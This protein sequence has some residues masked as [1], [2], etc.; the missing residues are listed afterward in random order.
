LNTSPTGTALPDGAPVCGLS[1]YPPAVLIT[2]HSHFN[3]SPTSSTVLVVPLEGTERHRMSIIRF[4]GCLLFV[5]VAAASATAMAQPAATT[6]KAS[7]LPKHDVVGSAYPEPFRVTNYGAKCDGKVIYG[8]VTV[9]QGNPTIST[10]SYMF[11][12]GDIGATI[13]LSI[14]SFNGHTAAALTSFSSS[15]VSVSKGNATMAD[16]ASFSGGAAARWYHTVDTSAIQAA[17]DAVS[18]SGVPGGGTVAFPPGVCVTGNLTLPS[19]IKIS[20]SGT[21]ASLIMLANGSN[22][23]MFTGAHFSDLTGTANTGGIADIAFEDITLDGNRGA[24]TASGIGTP[25]GK[26]DG[27]RIYGYE[28]S[29]DN[30]QINNFAG[31]AWYSEW[32]NTAGSPQDQTNRNIAP[33]GMEPHLHNLRTFYNAGYGIIFAGAHDAQISYVWLSGNGTGGLLNLGLGS[34][35]TVSQ[36]HSYQNGGFD[37]DAEA[38]YLKCTGCYVEGVLLLNSHDATFIDSTIGILQLGIRGGRSVYG[39]KMISDQVTTLKNYSGGTYNDTWIAGSIGAITG[40]PYA[41]N[42]TFQTNGLA[43]TTP[44]LRF[45]TGPSY[46]VTLGTNVS[47]QFALTNGGGQFQVD[48][49]GNGWVKTNLSVG[50][51]PLILSPDTIGITKV[52]GSNTAPGADGLK[53]EVTCGT[54]P[55]TAKLQAYAGTSTTPTTIMDNIG[56][57]LSGC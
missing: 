13:N 54:K 53:L 45:Q 2:H 24:N 21:A 7:D 34:P 10:L 43:N 3:E 50:N 12:T 37:V 28:F 5:I 31:D 4:N 27:V 14:P 42:G 8:G 25:V 19:N 38:P 49:T 47:S 20:G 55:G 30:V 52:T 40:A 23:D 41:P 56:S 6:G 18:G 32:S 44:N 36:L 9:A 57:G 33:A 29:V 48:A 46:P 35:L 22:S 16:K 1:A 26:G 15:I 11:T 17:I 51:S 39:L